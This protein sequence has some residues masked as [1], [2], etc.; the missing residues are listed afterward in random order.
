VTTTTS[1]GTDNTLYYGDNL[2]IMREHIPTASV[3]LVYL[4]PPF[5]SDRDYN[6]LFK[7]ESGQDSEAQITAFEDTWHWGPEAEATYHHLATEG[8]ERVA[9]MIGAMRS[10]IGA[11]QM[12]A[13]LVMM[14]VRLAELHR[15][16]KPTGSLYLHC[17]PT[18]SHYLKVI[19]DTI[20]GADQFRSEI[21]WRRTNSHNKTTRK[22][23]PIHDTI[24]FYSKTSTFTFHPGFRPYTRAYIE[25]RFTHVDE[26]GRFQT[27]Y[28]TGPG[29]RNGES[30]EAW[31][32]FNPTAV[33]RHWAIPKS[34][35]PYLP[36]DVE[37]LSSHQALEALFGQGLILFPKKEG[38]QPMYKQYIG[39]GVNYQD[40]W[41]YQPNTRGVL[42]G[43]D[44]SIDEDVKY[45]EDEDEKTGYETQ[46]PVGLLD[47]I[48]ITSTNPGDVIL[49]PFC[50]CGTAIISAQK[51]GR[52]WKG[53]DITHL[54]IALQKYRLEKMTPTPAFHVVGEPTDIGAARQLSLDDRYQFQWWALSLVRAKPLGGQEG[55]KTGKKG[56]DKGIDGVITFPED[57]SGKLR[58]AI[59]QVKSGKVKSG[60]IRDL[61]GTVQRENAAIGVFITLEQPTQEMTKEAV[62]AG[63]Y[64][65][66]PTGQDYPRIQILPVVDLLHGAEVKMPPTHGPFPGKWKA[67]QAPE[68][69]QPALDFG[70]ITQE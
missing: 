43:T 41:A 19:L 47:R 25:D 9:T 51:L 30:G 38:G 3:D 11:N 24:L 12:M 68:G 59:V 48:L 8:A 31:R 6:V 4:D 35:R 32:G 5:N 45:L 34:L 7:D 64:R 65:W 23:G 33:G 69:H 39:P 29:V 63:F 20:F 14:T 55:S 15:T 61:V 52:A 66:P 10:F 46:K 60:D 17:D 56:S 16:L 21:I 44:E 28:L 22:Y 37:K 26:R 42:Y 40:I 36:T 13:Y 58:R 67:R 1:T 50:G 54:S 70:V 27:N 57:A 18:A 53:I 49:D 2:D 62:T